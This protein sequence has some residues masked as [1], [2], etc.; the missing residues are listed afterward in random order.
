MKNRN[1][2]YIIDAS[3]DRSA[4]IQV[5][6]IVLTVLV[7]VL[8]VYFMRDFFVFMCDF[9]SWTFGGFANFDAYP[10]LK[11]L[12][13]IGGYI[14]ALFLV[15]VLFIG[16]SVYNVLRY[17]KKKR[18]KSAAPVDVAQTAQAYHV[19]ARDVGTWQKARTLVVHHDK[20]GHITDVVV[21]K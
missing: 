5:R 10:T 12:S 6:D 9:F 1:L 19:D 20:R 4:I 2:K 13:T 15:T 16:W 14:E 8:Y 17:G 21:E 3:D 11:I 18:R 7:W